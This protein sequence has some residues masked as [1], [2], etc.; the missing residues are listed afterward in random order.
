MNFFK[1]VFVKKTR[2]KNELVT[3]HLFYSVKQALKVKSRCEKE[4]K[5][6]FRG[7]AVATPVLRAAAAAVMGQS[8]G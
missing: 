3:V 1:V 4:K 6:K 8:T 7:C 2:E 5:K